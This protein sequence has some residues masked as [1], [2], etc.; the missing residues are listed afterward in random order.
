VPAKGFYMD[1]I[2]S[3]ENIFGRYAETQ[4]IVEGG[5]NHLE[6]AGWRSREGVNQKKL[7][8]PLKER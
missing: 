7:R 8:V 5:V 4:Q 3:D 6:H 2:R 1:V